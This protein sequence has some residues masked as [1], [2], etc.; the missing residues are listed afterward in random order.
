MNRDPQATPPAQASIQEGD[1]RDATLDELCAAKDLGLIGTEQIA[2]PTRFIERQGEALLLRATMSR[3]TAQHQLEDRPIFLRFPW[4][5]GFMGGETQFLGY[6][7]QEGRRFLRVRLPQRFYVDDHRTHPRIDLPNK[8]KGTAGSSDFTLVEVRVENLSLRGVGMLCLGRLP[9][10]GFHPGRVVSCSFTLEGGPVVQAPLR[11]VRSEGSFLG[12]VFHPALSGQA[13]ESLS[14]WLDSRIQKAR[15]V[16]EGRADRRAQAAERM[17]RLQLKPEGALV[18]GGDESLAEAL[19]G[20]LS[21][22]L[23]LRTSQLAMAPLKKALETLP[24]R[25]ILMDP[26]AVDSDSRRRLRLLMENLDFDGP[27][28]VLGHNGNREGARLLAEEL[29][30]VYTEWN[31]QL[32]VLFQRLIQGLLAKEDRP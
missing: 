3:E 31:P 32:G 22:G 18:A 17:A 5:L 4:G 24:P 21:P 10:Q 12:A 15:D 6:E 13:R 14:T 16:W 7:E 27:L 25:I 19:R 9:E 8:V 11:I 2:W 1:L 28:V 23:S 30:G 20:L 26:R 29:R